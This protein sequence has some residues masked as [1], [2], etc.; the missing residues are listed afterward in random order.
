MC[1]ARY[2]DYLMNDPRWKEASYKRKVE[3]KFRC[4]NCGN[5][6]SLRVHHL[7][8]EKNAHDVKPKLTDLITLCVKC[9]HGVHHGEIDI[10]E[11]LRKKPGDVVATLSVLEVNLLAYIS[12]LGQLNLYHRFIEENPSFQPSEMDFPEKTRGAV[13]RILQTLSTRKEFK[14]NYV[15]KVFDYEKERLAKIT[16]PYLDKDYQVSFL[17]DENENELFEKTRNTILLIRLLKRWN[18]QDEEYR[19]LARKLSVALE[20]KDCSVKQLITPSNSPT[21]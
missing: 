20:I 15:S 18:R 9:H 11:V 1:D 19:W 12:V 21:S 8:Y 4:R 16:N 10:N 5:T 6:S 7:R 17:I 2:R 14:A 3:D 13:K